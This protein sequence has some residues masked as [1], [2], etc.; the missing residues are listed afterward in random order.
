M[1]VTVPTGPVSPGLATPLPGAQEASRGGLSLHSAGRPQ[2]SSCSQVGGPWPGPSPPPSA[3]SY[4]LPGRDRMHARDTGPSD[5]GETGGPSV[6]SGVTRSPRTARD[7]RAGGGLRPSSKVTAVG[8]TP[9]SLG[10]GWEGRTSWGSGGQPGP[11]RTL[12]ARGGRVWL[13]YGTA[14]VALTPEPPRPRAA[15]SGGGVG[16]GACSS[17]GVVRGRAWA[18]RRPTGLASCC[19]VAAVARPLP[20]VPL[21]A[22]HSEPLP[23]PWGEGTCAEV[24]GLLSWTGQGPR[25][26][27]SSEP[28]HDSRG[29]R[30]G[31]A[32]REPAHFGPA[33]GRVGSQVACRGLRHFLLP[34]GTARGRCGR[35]ALRLSAR[36]ASAASPLPVPSSPSRPCPCHWQWPLPQSD[37]WRLSGPSGQPVAGGLHTGPVDPAAPSPAP[38]LRKQTMSLRRDGD[39]LREPRGVSP[40]RGPGL[41]ASG[42][43][44]PVLAGSMPLLGGCP[45]CDTQ[46]WLWGPGLG[47]RDS[48]APLEEGMVSPRGSSAPVDGSWNPWECFPT[49]PQPGTWT[50]TRAWPLGDGSSPPRG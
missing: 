36:R 13:C 6:G 3:A 50:P 18:G 22:P 16:R 2:S 5:L 12:G 4:R 17:A 26:S 48:S 33:S 32:P 45:A 7:E 20:P 38:A 31:P 11:Q 1:R 46:A 8:P 27:P 23:A 39:T 47:D 41:A 19:P 15:E 29:G 34:G 9:G 24:R 43:P 37:V 44:V 42:A 14:P 25:G 28:A 10:A 49:W 40:C 35:V 30:E 21:P